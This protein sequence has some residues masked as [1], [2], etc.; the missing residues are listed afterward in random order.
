MVRLH[1]LYA[2]IRPQAFCYLRQHGKQNIHANRHIRSKN[3]RHNLGYFL[4]FFHLRIRQTGSPQNKG[5]FVFS[6]IIK[7]FVRCLR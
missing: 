5:F 7:M 4:N 2:V 1:D 3:N 6:C